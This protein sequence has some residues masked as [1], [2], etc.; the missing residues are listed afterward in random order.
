M[1]KNEINKILL[2]L[3]YLDGQGIILV[4]EILLIQALKGFNLFKIE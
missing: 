4:N 2:L 1:T 3:D